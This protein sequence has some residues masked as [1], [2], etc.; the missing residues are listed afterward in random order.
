MRVWRVIATVTLIVAVLGAWAVKQARAPVSL[1]PDGAHEVGR[2]T[3]L[4]V[5]RGR[6]DQF[7]PLGGTPRLLSVWAWYPAAQSTAPESAYAPEGWEGLHRYGPAA[8]AFDRIRTGTRDEAPFAAGSFPVVVLL[9]DR[10]ASAPQYTALASQLAAQGYLVVGVTPTYSAGLTVL[11]GKPVRASAAGDPDRLDETRRAQLL[12][13]WA[14]DARFAASRALVQLGQHVDPAAVVYLGHGLGGAAAIA[15]CRDDERCAGS[16]SLG[17]GGSLLLAARDRTWAFTVAGAERLTF[18]DYALY[19]LAPPLRW[20]LPVGSI[21][22]RRALE[23]TS[24]YLTGF[25]GAA[26]LG[27]TWTPP[28]YPEVRPAAMLG[29]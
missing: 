15:A 17:D 13:V 9:P 28:S 23:I 24:G 25:L 16:A 5:D 20:A 29:R 27:R 7:A 26:I 14:A 22:G 2:I 10:G 21:D 11:D 8:T 4:W 1:R 12:S 6:T 3:G 18:T 19:R